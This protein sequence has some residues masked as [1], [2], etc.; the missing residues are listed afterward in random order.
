MTDQPQDDD[1]RDKTETTLQNA[2]DLLFSRYIQIEN[3]DALRTISKYFS[4]LAN[5]IDE[6]RYR[7]LCSQGLLE[8]FEAISLV[9]KDRLEH[10]PESIRHQIEEI[11]KEAKLLQTFAL[12][13]N[14][15]PEDLWRIRKNQTAAVCARFPNRIASFCGCKRPLRAFTEALIRNETWAKEDFANPALC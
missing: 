14:L 12:L 8:S 13:S 11:F 3:A 2:V 7:V 5:S 10:Y 15:P 4:H 6:R 9:L 1:D